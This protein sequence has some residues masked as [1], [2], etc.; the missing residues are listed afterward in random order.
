MDVR[1]RTG[2]MEEAFRAMLDGFK[3]SLWTAVPAIVQSVDFAK[4]TATLQPA[5]KSQQKMPDGSVKAVDIPLLTDVP[6]HFPTGGGA[7]MTFPVKAGDEALVVFSS[8][9]SDAW[10]QSGGVRS[11]IDARTHDLSDGFAMVGFR[12]NNKALANVSDDS[13]QL[14]SDSGNT[15]VSLKEDDVKVKTSG[16]SGT[17]T[18]S[19]VN[20]TVGEMLV[21]ITPSRVDL[22]GMG[23]SRVSTEAGPSN[24]VYAVL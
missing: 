16:S 2:D 24:K 17:F 14:R 18:P 6:M 8:R 19:Q 10:Q 7:S 11:Q 12:S 13:V 5:I 22:G 1:E 3:A 15:T 21:N 20:M 4:Q 9:P 23:G